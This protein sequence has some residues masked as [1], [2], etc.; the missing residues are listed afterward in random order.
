MFAGTTS[1]YRLLLADCAAPMQQEALTLSP[2]DVAGLAWLRRTLVHS[3][4]AS[5]YDDIRG[6]GVQP[7][8]LRV[9]RGGL[10]L[11]C[12]AFHRSVH[13]L[14]TLDTVTHSCRCGCGSARR[15][16]RSAWA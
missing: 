13:S 16:G 2:A 7:Q 4:A 8:S 14:R 6:G 12:V 3:A 11:R 9:I 10:A 5:V 1:R 15:A